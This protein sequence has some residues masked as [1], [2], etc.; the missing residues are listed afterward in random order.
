MTR[1][2]ALVPAAVLASMLA[3]C[4]VETATTA[5]TS[6]EIKKRELEAGQKNLEQAKQKLEAATQSVQQGA[7]Q[8]EEK[9][10]D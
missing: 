10:K 9:S 2:L 3:A 7:A 8:A 5:A 1:L 4:G 6:A